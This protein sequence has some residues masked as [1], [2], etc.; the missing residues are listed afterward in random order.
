MNKRLRAFL[1]LD[2]FGTRV[3][4]KNTPAC[5]GGWRGLP[6]PTRRIRNAFDYTARR[7][8]KRTSNNRSVFYADRMLAQ[9][10]GASGPGSHTRGD[11]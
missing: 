2:I 6:C 10:F 1:V 3:R 8:P 5:P 11:D 9:S 7:T 4:A